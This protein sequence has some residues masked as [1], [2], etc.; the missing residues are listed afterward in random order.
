ML[1]IKHLFCNI[2]PVLKESY[3]T[4][5][6]PSVVDKRYILSAVFSGTVLS[7]SVKSFTVTKAMMYLLSMKLEK[8]RDRLYYFGAIVP[9]CHLARSSLEVKTLGHGE[10]LMNTVPSIELEKFEDSLYY[11]GVIFKTNYYRA[12]QF[13]KYHDMELLSIESKEE[14]DFLLKHVQSLRRPMVFKNWGPNQ[15]DN[16]N[17]TENCLE[18]KYHNQIKD[19]IWNDRACNEEVH[20]VCETTVPKS[21]S[22]IVAD[23]FG[24]GEYYFWTS[25]TTMP[26]DHWVWLSTGRPIIFANWFP[27]QPDDAGK[28]EK[29]L[30]VRYSNHNKALMWNDHVCTEAKHVICETTVPKSISSMVAAYPDSCVLDLH[31]IQRQNRITTQIL[32]N[33]IEKKLFGQ[34]RSTRPPSIWDILPMRTRR[35]PPKANN[36]QEA[37]NSPNDNETLV[38]G[39]SETVSA[40]RDFQDIEE[41]GEFHLP[42]SLDTLSLEQKTSNKNCP[43]CIDDSLPTP[44]RWTMPLLKLGEKRYY[45]GIFFKANY[46]RATQYCRFHG[47]HLASITSQEEN[48]KLE[49][50]IKDFGF[51]ND[52]FWTSGTDLAVEGNFFWM[53]TGRPI[54]FTNWNAGEPNNFE[55]E[56]GEQENCLEL[57]NRDGKGLKWNDSPCSFET[58]FVCEVQS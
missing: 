36:I 47:M 3:E 19:L 7:N 11:F 6:G 8:F 32:Q 49:K 23:N 30:E 53:S 41:Q 57:W 26:D 2:Q 48:D 43:N 55:Y 33:Y 13:C 51:G 21:I 14:N 58:Y 50:Y 5:N 27:N 28:N 22:S 9:N 1:N 44:N 20:W 38:S 25:G 16:K 34:N 37:I 15:P 39:E 45:L 29:C 54:T 40:Y 10:I 17:K 4:Q 35:K 42:F 52:H 46:Y 12:M 24:W 31:E 56:N 18:V